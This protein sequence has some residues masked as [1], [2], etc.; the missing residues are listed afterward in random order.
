MKKCI[1]QGCKTKVGKYNPLC[2]SCYVMLMSGVVT[3]TRSF[4]K[5]IPWMREKLI[6][7]KVLVTMPGDSKDTVAAITELL[8][9][10]E[11]EE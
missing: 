9:D 6:Q 5:C 11:S 4:L 10:V 7:T 1:V 3:K 8:K 2:D